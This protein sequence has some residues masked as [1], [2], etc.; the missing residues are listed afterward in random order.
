MTAKS[1]GSPR[2]YTDC[3]KRLYHYNHVYTRVIVF[4]AI[5]IVD[6]SDSFK[7]PLCTT[8][9]APIMI[10]L[11]ALGANIKKKWLPFPKIF[12][13]VIFSMGRSTSEN[14]SFTYTKISSISLRVFKCCSCTSSS[15]KKHYI[16]STM[17][18]YSILIPLFFLRAE[19]DDSH[20]DIASKLLSKIIEYKFYYL[21][22]ANLLPFFYFVING[23]KRFQETSF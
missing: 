10:H 22:S 8:P 9:K 19:N 7:S 5:G 3:S 6:S 12:C 18:I 11:Y 4:I 13:F 1:P 23:F 15:S 14:F 21:K 16:Y 2:N 20:G 17:K